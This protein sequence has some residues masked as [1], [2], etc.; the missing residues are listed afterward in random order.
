MGIDR[1]AVWGFS[2]GGPHAL[3]CAALLPDLVSAVASLASLAPYGA[4]GLDYF[5]GMGKDNVEDIQLLLNDPATAR[6]RACR[7]VM[8]S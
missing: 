5:T 1:L 2:G 8:Q 3:A 7:I 6:R 4:P